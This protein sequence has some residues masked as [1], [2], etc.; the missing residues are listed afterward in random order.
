MKIL[1]RQDQQKIYKLLVNLLV[2]IVNDESQEADDA[3]REVFKVGR[4]TGLE[5]ALERKE[6][7][8]VLEE[9]TNYR[10]D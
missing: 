2:Y 5:K 6:M 10:D 7:V 3:L 1:R 9:K 8:E 4:L